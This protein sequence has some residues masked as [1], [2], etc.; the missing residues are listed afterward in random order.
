M[1][2]VRGRELYV[3]DVSCKSK[4]ISGAQA[5]L[6][7]RRVGAGRAG[8]AEGIGHRSAGV[9]RRAVR[10][11]RLAE[12]RA[13]RIVVDQ[14]RGV[15]LPAVVPGT[16][17]LQRQPRNDARNERSLDSLDI[18]I[19]AVGVVENVADQAGVEEGHLDIVPGLLVDGAVPLQ[20]VAEEFRLPAD[21]VVGQLVGLIRARNEVLSHAIRAGG[22]LCATVLVEP[23]WAEA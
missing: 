22:M 6:D 19:L 3:R 2:T 11:D 9:G 1:T 4:L 10:C 13:V 20:A 17:R 15:G 23:A 5:E 12:P 16:C 21:L 14:G 8:R 18:E 7:R